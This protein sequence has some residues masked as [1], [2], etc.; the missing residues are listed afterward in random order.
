MTDAIGLVAAELIEDALDAA[1]AA[2]PMPKTLS[3]ARSALGLKMY[4]QANFSGL[5]KVMLPNAT[6][7]LLVRLHTSGMDV[8][9]VFPGLPLESSVALLE[10]K[11]LLGDIVKL[12]K[13]TE[14]RL[15]VEARKEK[16]RSR[17]GGRAL[18]P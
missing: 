11:M 6:G 7:T 18:Q 4:L 12:E 9:D 10:L 5:D 13:K 15:A 1:G 16:R 8:A 17:T 14:H 3:Q 2:M